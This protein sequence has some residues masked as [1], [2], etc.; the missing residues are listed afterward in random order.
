MSSVKTLKKLTPHDLKDAKAVD[1]AFWDDNM[2]CSKSQRSDILH[3]QFRHDKERAKR[4]KQKG[5]K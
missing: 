2:G 5:K 3:A 1:D 4:R